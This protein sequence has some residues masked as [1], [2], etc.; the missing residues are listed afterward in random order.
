MS[1]KSLKKSKKVFK[2][3]NKSIYIYIYNVQIICIIFPN[4]RKIPQKVPKKFHKIPKKLQT[5]TKS[6]KKN[7]KD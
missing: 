6:Y 7:Q 3:H 4:I 5:V 1:K 2:S